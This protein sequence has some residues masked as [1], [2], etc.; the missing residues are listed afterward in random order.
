MW[1]TR[2]EYEKMV[3]ELVDLRHRVAIFQAVEVM[4]AQMTPPA[5][6]VIPAPEPEKADTQS[7]NEKQKRIKELLDSGTRGTKW[8]R[9]QRRIEEA[10][11]TQ[12]DEIEVQTPA[13]QEK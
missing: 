9:Y 13:T 10:L 8:R 3:A 11:R 1:I 12:P 7:L 2:I 5:P 6:I 4:K